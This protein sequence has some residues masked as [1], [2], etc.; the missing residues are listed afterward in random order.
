MGRD[1]AGRAGRGGVCVQEV[2][3]DKLVFPRCEITQ[4]QLRRRE[5]NDAIIPINLSVRIGIFIRSSRLSDNGCVP[6]LSPDPS[7]LFEGA[8]IENENGSLGCHR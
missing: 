3:A 7:K 4:L 5:R 2:V 1:G 8:S 6:S